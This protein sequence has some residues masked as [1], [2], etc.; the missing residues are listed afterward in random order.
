MTFDPQ[1]P[2][3]SLPFAGKTYELEGSFGLIEAVEYALKDNIL[4]IATRCTAMPVHE[5]A[6]L[7]A[8]IISF[9]SEKTTASAI[10]EII[11]KEIGA[12]GDDYTMLCLHVHAFLRI[13]MAKPTERQAV[14]K[15]MGELLAK[16]Q[17]LSPSLGKTTD[18]SV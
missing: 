8:A 6:K 7:L 4:T 15:D 14:A 11:W 13:T 16:A 9:C 2:R 12:V 3:Y 18:A 17:S 10:G 1:K 5:M